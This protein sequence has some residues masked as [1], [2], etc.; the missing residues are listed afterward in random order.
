VNIAVLVGASLG[1]VVLQVR[2]PPSWAVPLAITLAAMVAIWWTQR[3]RFADPPAYLATLGRQPFRLLV[4]AFAAVLFVDSAAGFWFIP[5]AQRRFGV[6]AA[7]AGAQL[8]GL[9]IGGGI[10]GCLLGGWTADRWH[11]AHRAGRVYTA[12]LAVLVEGAAI[13]L[14]AGQ[15]NYHAFLAAFTVLCLGSGGWTGVAA[16]L[17][18]D[19]LPPEHRGT[20]T[21][22]Y[23]LVTTVLGPGLGPFLVGL[24][25]DAFGSLG[26]ALAASCATM[27][28]GVIALIKLTWWLQ[29]PTLLKI[30]AGP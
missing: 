20:G 12:L 6:G 15:T 3:L 30:P 8:G 11:R 10:I 13:W 7:A 4:A 18:L 27:V 25:S 19:L 16:A 21:A 1:A 22:A 2:L 29:R 14:A 9:L 5:F 28:L 24:G 17:A 26:T 23:F